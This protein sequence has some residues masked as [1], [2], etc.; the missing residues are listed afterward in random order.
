MCNHAAVVLLVVHG[1]LWGEIS[2]PATHGASA[3]FS[4]ARKSHGGMQAP[5][6]KQPQL[7]LG[8]RLLFA[9]GMTVLCSESCAFCLYRG[10]LRS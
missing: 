6:V 5:G 7:P 4:L 10:K 8:S 9:G 1:L 2:G 3:M